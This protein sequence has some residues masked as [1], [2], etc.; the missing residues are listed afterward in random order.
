M[1]SD[2]IEE[3]G[4]IQPA[5]SLLATTPPIGWEE[6]VHPRV[7]GTCTPRAWRLANMRAS[8]KALLTVNS[9]KRR[10]CL[11]AIAGSHPPHWP[12]E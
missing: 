8:V 7:W 3:V 2:R 5:A 11:A 4:A 1:V 9:C 12:P 10:A 6:Y